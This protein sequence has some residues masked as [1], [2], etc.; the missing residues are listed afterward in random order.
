MAFQ[1]NMP[2]AP[3][4]TVGKLGSPVSGNTLSSLADITNIQAAQQ[5]IATNEQSLKKAQATFGSDVARSKAESET[6]QTGAQRSELALNSEKFKY[7]RD[8]TTNTVQ[9]IQKLYNKENLTTD[10][11][12]KEA[13][14]LNKNQGGNEQTLQQTLSSLPPAGSP[15]SAL[16]AWLANSL[17]TVN[18]AQAQMDK[19]FPNVTPTNIGGAVVPT[20]SGNPMLAATAPGTQTGKGVSTTIAPQVVS[21]QITGAPMVIGGRG[22]SGQPLNNLMQ[23]NAP[24]GNVQP[25]TQPQGN[26]QPNAPRAMPN[27]SRASDQLQQMPNESPANFNNRVALT[28]S[29]VT[30]AQDQFN[31]PNSE[32]GHIPT[33]K[34][35]NGNILSLLK[36]PSVNT[37]SVQ[38]YI[39]GKFRQENLS[40]K[41][42]ELAKYLA[43]RVQNLTP[44][45]DADADAKRKAYGTLELKKEAL[46]DLIRQDNAWVTTQE[47]QAKGVLN[48]GGDPS[49]PNFG[50]VAQFNN[51]FAKLAQNPA[52][53]KYIGIVGESQ[54]K[55]SL[56]A[57]DLKALQK[58]IGSMKPEARQALELQR[59]TLLKLVNGGQ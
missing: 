21:N 19:M 6:A 32:F 44:K 30:K 25:N 13:T 34:S 51:Q 26:V 55:V 35:I 10:D 59:K 12:V 14:F 42:Q 43:Q 58:E 23:S 24:Q 29:A 1:L 54:G 50:R 9:S 5:G 46:I 36:D 31:N 28:Q 27:A 40:A 33:V 17:A 7:L 16:Q 8:Q 57:D 56:D 11:I 53:M 41:E 47:L 45:S 4:Y 2:S 38:S 37:G 49:N 15:K 20:A 22:E 3:S 18:T 52:L 48:N 39:A